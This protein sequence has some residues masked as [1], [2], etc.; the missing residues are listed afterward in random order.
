[1]VCLILI[2]VPLG[3]GGRAMWA[4]A[5][6]DK[7]AIS[8]SIVRA[9]PLLI[10]GVGIAIA[11]QAGAFNIG[12]EGQYLVGA[13][14]SGVTGNV[15]LQ[16][17]SGISPFVAISAMLLASIIGG[18]AWSALAAWMFLG[19][20]VDLVIST[21]LLNFVADKLLLFMIDGPIKMAGQTAPLSDRLPR[22]WMLW[23]PNPQLDIHVGVLF[24]IFIAVVSG[25]V[26]FR[27][28]GGYLVRV[29]GLNPRF[30]RANRHDPVQ[31]KYRAML[32]SG[33]I[34]GFAGGVQFLA[35]NA[36]LQ[37]S[38][39]QNFGFLAIP[40]ALLGGLNPL[41]IIFSAGFFGSLFAATS[42]LSR[43]TGSGTY[44]VYIIQGLAVFGLLVFRRVSKKEIA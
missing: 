44:F 41:A 14:F 5:F 26:L 25:V 40:V 43:F 29:V 18:M 17:A 32:C 2:G 19:R 9:T 27:T 31:I 37:P 34:C 38:F 39:S 42:N 21:I 28:K 11:W 24:A 1:M 36:Q 13:L 15:L 16:S 4:G 6:G 33:A 35:I 22:S 12:G 30:A 8:Q 23:K 10:L 7:F 20:G 3:E